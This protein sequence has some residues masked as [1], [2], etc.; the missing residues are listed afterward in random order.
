MP[1][2]FPGSNLPYESSST[3]PRNLTKRSTT[4]RLASELLQTQEMTRFLNT[5]YINTKTKAQHHLL[6]QLGLLVYVFAFY[7]FIKYC[8]SASLVPLILHCLYQVLMSSEILTNS[9]D[10]QVIRNILQETTPENQQQSV[11]DRKI[12]FV[13]R[14]IYCKSLFIVIYHILFVCSWMV[15]LVNQAR[16]NEL[17]HGTWWFVSFIGEEVPYIPASIPYY[18][19]VFRLGLGQLIFTD[20]MIMLI[21]LIMFQSIYKQS[22]ILQVD[23][24]LNEP[25]VYG[26]RQSTNYTGSVN[27][28]D[29]SREDVPTV[30]KVRLYQCFK[31]EGYLDLIE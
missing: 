18:S 13:C 12:T 8:H 26:V 22:P 31:M 30:L 19:K 28:E 21:E 15:S 1:G 10:L 3:Q 14:M 25:E 4:E 16:L 11:L 24:R 23:R 17:V 29:V 5:T 6:G 2:S 20:L 7:Q 9:P 27:D